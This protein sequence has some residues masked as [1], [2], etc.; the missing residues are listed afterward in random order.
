[1]PRAGIPAAE[2]R[3]IL[4]HALIAFE[5][6]TGREVE[7]TRTGVRLTQ[8][9]VDAEI[10]LPDGEQRLVV[11]KRNVTPATVGQTVAQA[12]RFER[13]FLLITRYVTVPLAERL[14]ERQVDFIDTAGNA[15]LH[16]PKLLVYITGRKLPAPVREEK[17]TRLLKPAGLKVLF[18][19]LC[20][21]ELVNAPYREI[22]GQAG[23]ALGTVAWVFDDLR[24][25]GFVDETKARG[26]VLREELALIDRWIEGYAQQL[27][28]RLRPKRFSV[29]DPA[30]WQQAPLADFDIWLGGEP[31]AGILTN[32]LRPQV[33]TIY[34]DTRLTELARR[35]RPIKDEFG[36]LEI[37]QKFWPFE[38]PLLDDRYPLV[39][40]LLIYADLVATADP[41]NIETAQIIRERY[42]VHR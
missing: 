3:Q 13:P 11:V 2:E 17:P 32:Y 14:K 35:I 41:R 7:L 18:T 10:R 28:P 38:G 33:V 4:D 27:R 12:R 36:N 26:R 31:A 21:P 39:P 34:G 23:V 24:R 22:A 19:L 42:L 1:M 16:T 9:T 25:L 37:L 8:G 29:T 30:W 20:V 6:T 5:R 40:P 15:Y